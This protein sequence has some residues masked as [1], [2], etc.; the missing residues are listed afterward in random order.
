[1]SLE[2]E[3]HPSG[4]NPR[5]LEKLCAEQFAN[6]IALK[7]LPFIELYFCD[8]ELIQEFLAPNPNFLLNQLLRLKAYF[9]DDTYQWLGHKGS[10]LRSI[11]N[12]AIADVLDYHSEVTEGTRSLQ[13]FTVFTFQ[14]L[15]QCEAG[16]IST[17]K[18]F[19]ID[20]VSRNLQGFLKIVGPLQ[21]RALYSSSIVFNEV[22]SFALLLKHSPGLK[23]IQL[24]RSYNE[25]ILENL[26]GLCP[27][28]EDIEL[29]I[30]ACEDCEN[31][32][33]SLCKTFFSSLSIK[34]IIK[35]IIIRQHIDLSF[36]NL[37]N[38][39]FYTLDEYRGPSLNWLV[40]FLKYLYPELK[41]KWFCSIDGV[42][43]IPSIIQSGVWCPF[44][45]KD[46]LYRMSLD[47][48]AFHLEDSDEEYSTSNDLCLQ[49]FLQCNYIFIDFN[50]HE[51]IGIPNFIEALLKKF[52]CHS[53]KLSY[54][55][56]DSEHLGSAFQGIGVILKELYLN[57]P[58]FTLRDGEQLYAI[59]NSCINL[60]ILS[61]N[62]DL[63][64]RHFLES[65]NELS[66]LEVLSFKISNY[67]L[68]NYFPYREPRVGG[69]LRERV[70]NFMT[71]N[72][73]REDLPAYLNS[74][75]QSLDFL[76]QNSQ[77]VFTNYGNTADFH[78]EPYNPYY[79]S[80]GFSSVVK[81]LSQ[82]QEEESAKEKTFGPDP[83]RYD[84]SSSGS[85]F[86]IYD[87]DSD[88]DEECASATV[89][90]SVCPGDKILSFYGNAKYGFPHSHKYET[91]VY[92]AKCHEKP[93]TSQYKENMAGEASL[94]SEGIS[95]FQ[96]TVVKLDRGNFGIN[97][98]QT[99]NELKQWRL[100]M[101][102][103]APVA[104]L[105][106][107]I[108]SS[109]NLKVLEIPDLRIT[110]PFYIFD[111][112]NILTSLSQVHTLHLTC[113]FTTPL[114][115][116]LVKLISLETLRID[117]SYGIDNFLRFKKKLRRTNLMVESG[118][119]LVYPGSK[120]STSD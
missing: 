27:T 96:D 101:D 95:Y 93:Q 62:L 53:L 89:T 70:K 90:P 52:K 21:I 85:G 108:K 5:R 103:G 102:Y 16:R 17:R 107:L 1:M 81:C 74:P 41:A 69:Y 113:Q 92:K 75:S 13:I 59:L 80:T 114:V 18:Y 51:D 4:K 63:I 30:T 35:R 112:H 98:K 64:Y 23:F 82:L 28:I 68:W 47:G 45:A 104:L 29:E 31:I 3:A 12:T 99:E 120:F 54:S 32:E 110:D 20:P 86:F 44:F 2:E 91:M 26:Q 9:W 57:G 8:R 66:N 24:H 65:V 39:V 46:E 19:V 72:S 61:I 34:E 60:K 97:L 48:V 40:F 6:D 38:V 83:L 36:P 100:D 105:E 73:I 50:G 106:T 37:K 87:E 42:S 43:L 94:L 10:F 119:S 49:L 117:T 25:A 84:L 71:R 14:L 7:A 118:G 78:G 58:L 76:M 33:E 88:D 111:T 115:Q 109:P 11:V 77:N 15:F 22:G 116:S 56:T 79:P 67:P 55:I